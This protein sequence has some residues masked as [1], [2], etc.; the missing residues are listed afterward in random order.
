[1]MNTPK[2]VAFF[3]SGEGTTFRAFLEHWKQ[4]ILPIQP[5]LLVTNN[6]TCG[7]VTIANEF[8]VEVFHISSKTHP[9]EETFAYEMLQKLQDANIELILLVGYMKKLPVNVI[10]HYK[11]FIY[12]THPALLPKY[13][14]KGMYGINVHT[15]VLQNNE[16]ESGATI[17]L[18]TEEYDEGQI[19]A[20]TVV[21]V[22]PNDTPATLQERVKIAERTLYIETIS[23]LV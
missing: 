1:M 2:N 12:N 15:A 14:G 18:V 10:E 4:G 16:T 11:G 23:T 22:V 6:S 9:N 5:A 21:P 7:A 17:H 8:G 3:A 19:I 20:Q 13:G